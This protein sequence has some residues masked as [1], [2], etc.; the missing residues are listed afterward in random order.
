[1]KAPLL[2]QGPCALLLCGAKSYRNRHLTQAI[3]W[4]CIT[5]DDTVAGSQDLKCNQMQ[6]NAVRTART[7]RKLCMDQ[8]VIDSMIKWIVTADNLGG[9]LF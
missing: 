4:L 9:V 5:D 6:P 2:M 1:M 3:R 7:L 8:F